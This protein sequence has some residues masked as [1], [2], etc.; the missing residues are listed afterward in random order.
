MD[1]SSAEETEPGTQC[2][3]RGGIAGRKM[4]EPTAPGGRRLFWPICVFTRLS[5]RDNS[6]SCHSRDKAHTPCSLSLQVPQYHLH[7]LAAT[8]S[9][10]YEKGRVLLS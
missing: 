9:A 10:R 7:T 4:A 3:A 2:E 1:G 5:P 6:A 8:V